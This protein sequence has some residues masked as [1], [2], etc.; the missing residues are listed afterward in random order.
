MWL[1]NTTEVLS[2][3]LLLLLP[4]ILQFE[5]QDSVPEDTL[6]LSFS[7]IVIGF[8]LSY[9][10]ER[11]SRTG[12]HITLSSHF[13]SFGWRFLTWEKSGPQVTVTLLEP[14]A[15][16]ECLACGYYIPTIKKH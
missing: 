15:Y 10:M 8:S 16:T 13:Y 9:Q 1:N 12:S 4:W 7:P 11:S 6:A 14:A 5:S 3:A 2:K